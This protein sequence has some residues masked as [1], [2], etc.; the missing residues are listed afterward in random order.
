MIQ[1]SRFILAAC[2]LS[3]C[4][5]AGGRNAR[6]ERIDALA[7]TIADSVFAEQLAPG[8][9]VLHLVHLAEPWRAAVLE[10]N[11][12][13]CVSIRAVKGANVA[14]GRT[15]TSA[16]LT[17][18][19]PALHPLAAVNADFFLFTPP[20]VPTNVHVEQRRLLSGPIDRAAFAMTTAGRPWIGVF[21]A[22]AQLQTPR[23]TIHLKTWNRPS[24]TVSGVVD[25]AWGIPLDSVARKAA[26]VLT[27][28]A[29]TNKNAKDQRYVATR[30]PFARTPIATGDTLLIVGLRNSANAALQ[31]LAGDTVRVSRTLAPF[32][33]AE[34]VG[35]QPHLMRDS[36][37]LGTVDSAGN[38]GFRG[39]NPR[40]A[41]GYGNKGKRLL[42][43]VIDGRQPG[44]SVGM[45]LRQEADLF[46]ALGATDAM[47]LDGGGSSVMVVRDANATSRVR[48]L[49]HPSD[50]VGQR[51]VSNALAVLR[52]CQK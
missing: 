39:L 15:T 38:A 2:L 37:I 26:W 28:I 7:H 8:V 47:N 46:R 33:P 25:A 14:V 13:A 36:I 41:I 52:S 6:D 21:N 51:A 35:G 20:G 1:R 42:L 9:R 16:L 34:A 29:T 19:D 12:D 30:L 49:T 45:T 3:A 31:L 22:L 27:P 32:M 23:G 4:T 5:S 50:T 44:F 17:S 43:A 48:L 40:T 11:L 18:I 10:V 24:G